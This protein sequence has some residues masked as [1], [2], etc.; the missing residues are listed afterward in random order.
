MPIPDIHETRTW[1]SLISFAVQRIVFGERWKSEYA[2]LITLSELRLVGPKSF[3]ELWRLSP[4]E[5]KESFSGSLRDLMQSGLIAKE[6]DG[7]TTTPHGRIFLQSSI[8]HHNR[9]RAMLL[10][11]HK[12][13]LGKSFVASISKSGIRFNREDFNVGWQFLEKLAQSEKMAKSSWE[14]DIQDLA[15]Q[16]VRVLTAISGF[17]R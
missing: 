15:Y 17:L 12:S 7:Y 8:T 13:T 2:K 6:E 16:I 9:I 3:T 1:A 11:R 5:S 10:A 4:L 14:T